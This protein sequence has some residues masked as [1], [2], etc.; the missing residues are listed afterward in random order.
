MDGIIVTYAWMIL[1]SGSY[2][3]S[4]QFD[5]EDECRKSAIT[6]FRQMQYLYGDVALPQYWKCTRIELRQDKRTLEQREMR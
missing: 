2:L 5:T 1:A 4:G 6:Q 3:A